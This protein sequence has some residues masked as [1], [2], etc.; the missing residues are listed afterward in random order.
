MEKMCNPTGCESTPKEE[1]ILQRNKRAAEYLLSKNKD[2][3]LLQGSIL[4]DR[5]RKIYYNMKEGVK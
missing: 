2:I 4:Y 3:V 1:E 5:K